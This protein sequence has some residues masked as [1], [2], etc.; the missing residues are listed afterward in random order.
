MARNREL[1]AS[2]RT[3][4][5]YGVS[6]K[7]PV[8]NS[9]WMNPY[10][11][12]HAGAT[13]RDYATTCEC[14][15]I[16]FVVRA[17]TG[18]TPHPKRCDHCVGHELEGTADQQRTALREHHNRY[19]DVVAKARKMTREAMTAK[20]SAQRELESGRQQ[21]AAAL[22]SRDRHGGIHE[23]VMSQHVPTGDGKCLCGQRFPC[24]TWDAAKTAR[25]RFGDPEEWT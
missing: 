18:Q 6:E 14:C 3:A 24:P 25:D 17:P 20:E 5:V 16:E 7:V 12:G 9:R 1:R 22:K 8:R 15:E 21:V 19:P 10:A 4:T 2:E 13:V 11:V 23:A